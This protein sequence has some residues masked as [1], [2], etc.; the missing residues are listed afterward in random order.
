[1]E[2]QETGAAAPPAPDGASQ[3]RGRLDRL[4][5]DLE[6]Q[7]AEMSAILAPRRRIDGARLNMH[8]LAT[9]QLVHDGHRMLADSIRLRSSDAEAAGEDRA[10]Q[11]RSQ[12]AWTALG[13]PLG[14]MRLELNKWPMV[15]SAL[16]PQVTPRRTPLFED[17]ALATP[18]AAA[19]EEITD[20]LFEQLHGLLNAG[21]QD[22]AALAHGCYADIPLDQSVFLRQ[23]HAA[24]RCLKVLRPDRPSSFIDVG[25]GAGLKVISAAPYFDR[26]TGLEYDSG[27]AALAREHFLALPHGRCR[28]IE[29]DALEFAGY[30]DHDVIY[31]YQPIRETERLAQM[32]R[33]IIAQ[34]GPR[35]LLIAPYRSF[36]QRAD[37][38]DG[39]VHVAGHIWMTGS[40]AAEAA[41]LCSEAEH[42]GTDILQSGD[43]NVPLIWDPLTDMSRNRGYE[44]MQ[45]ETP[46]PR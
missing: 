31:F 28:A 20:L 19:R 26:C 7:V 46:R 43:G 41:E 32:E 22:E 42:I 29:G 3:M 24:R 25:C 13:I 36:G 33:R 8:L 6:S 30:G 21:G 15:E 44:P 39:C 23:V 18:A 34:A 17:P 35:T 45:R 12:R 4:R 16:R 10:A 2:Q 38:Y 9:G 5:Q 14:Q 27:Y 1:M 37:G 40:S 11:D